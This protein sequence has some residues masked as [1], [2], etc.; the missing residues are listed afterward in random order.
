[1][2]GKMHDAEQI[3]ADYLAELLTP[4]HATPPPAPAEVKVVAI[5]SWRNALPEPE[6]DVVRSAPRYLLCAAAG[7]RVA[8]PMADVTHMLPMPPLS[9]PQHSNRMCL[10][11]WRH[12]S[13]E[14][15]VADL[16]AILSPDMAGAPAPTLVLLGD[17]RWAL[18][19]EVT[20]EPVALDTANVQWRDG[21]ATR[22]WL[23]GMSKEP[24]CG[25]IGTAALISWLEQELGS[26]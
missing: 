4:V 12:P 15:R 19:C 18:A 6:P 3:V 13:G 11:R 24:R 21:A 7:V 20:D 2:I 22:P 1:M 26:E 5:E 25:V 16:A 23:I 17:R 8:V 9:P 10:G 14:A